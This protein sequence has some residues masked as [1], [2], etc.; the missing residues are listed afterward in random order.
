[1]PRPADVGGSGALVFEQRPGSCARQGIR[2]V[3]AGAVG[4]LAKAVGRDML[5]GEVLTMADKEPGA[6]NFALI[7]AICRGEKGIRG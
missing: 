5:W 2:A 6:V 7:S 3:V 4:W 1:M